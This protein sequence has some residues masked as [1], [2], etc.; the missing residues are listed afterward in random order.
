MGDVLAARY[1]LVQNGNSESYKVECELKNNFNFL[2]GAGLWDRSAD[3]CLVMQAVGQA[4]HS[5]SLRDSCNLYG[6]TM[7]A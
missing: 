4:G 1:L 3:F 5:L 6:E 7:L 2:N